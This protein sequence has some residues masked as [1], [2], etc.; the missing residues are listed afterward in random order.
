MS[1]DPSHGLSIVAWL[2][3]VAYVLWWVVVLARRRMKLAEGRPPQPKGRRATCTYAL[4]QDEAQ[5]CHLSQ[6]NKL[7]GF[8]FGGCENCDKGR[9]RWVSAAEVGRF[10]QD[11]RDGWRKADGTI[12]DLALYKEA[13]KRQLTPT[14]ILAERT[15]DQ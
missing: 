6:V 15:R 14:Q 10:E 3:P 5:R 11:V 9:P 13:F 12:C 4:T 1:N 7:A 8:D 2:I